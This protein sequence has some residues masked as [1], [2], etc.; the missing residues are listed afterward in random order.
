MRN[1][2]S[3]TATW[4][5]GRSLGV[6]LTLA[7]RLRAL[8]SAHA[9]LMHDHHADALLAGTR[10]GCPA[11]AVCGRA[12]REACRE[13]GG[14][15]RCVRLDGAGNGGMHHIT[16]GSRLPCDGLGRHD[17]PTSLY[18][19]V[20][21]G[22]TSLVA[23][24]RPQPP[25]PPLVVHASSKHPTCRSASFLRVTSA[26]A[27]PARTHARTHARLQDRVRAC[28]R[29]CG[30]GRA[31]QVQVRGP[32]VS[33]QAAAAAA[34][35]VHFPCTPPHP[36][37]RP[38]PHTHMQKRYINQ[39]RTSSWH[40]IMGRAPASARD[41]ATSARPVRMTASARQT[42]AWESSTDVSSCCSC[43]KA[44]RASRVSE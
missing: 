26:V 22:A 18:R 40:I 31:V 28:M 3:W 7:P 2:A 15:R 42:S 12:M 14:T 5:P 21:R 10:G 32:Q 38:P 9:R 11:Y 16:R 25:Q 13:A 29:V 41:T 33:L 30:Q 37:L 24:T 39:N 23:C 17:S 36:T 20:Q 43:L 4:Q 27:A 34:A 8:Y 1:A 6:W 44:A 35:H 19:Y